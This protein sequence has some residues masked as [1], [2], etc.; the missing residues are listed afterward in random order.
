MDNEIP[1]TSQVATAPKSYKARIFFKS[2]PSVVYRAITTEEGI[3][4]WWTTDCE[5][6]GSIGATST[7]RFGKTRNVMRIDK[8]DAEREV[9]WSVVEQYHHAPG[10]ISRTN[11]WEGTVIT[12][13]LFPTDE[14]GTRL[15]FRHEGLTPELDCD[16]ICDS[17]WNRF[18]K[19]SLP[20]YVDEGKGNP[21]VRGA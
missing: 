14:S 8:L 17:G 12:F 3:Q 6:G 2:P 15:D 1:R 7:V 21:A 16:E 5:V 10:H 18:L 11:E 4:G 20:A 13:Q 19:S 9:R